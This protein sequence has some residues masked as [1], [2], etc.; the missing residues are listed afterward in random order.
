MVINTSSQLASVPK[1][2]NVTI[3]PESDLK[4]AHLP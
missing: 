4:E 1:L 2:E 3:G